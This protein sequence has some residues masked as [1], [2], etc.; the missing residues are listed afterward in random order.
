MRA[1]SCDVLLGQRRLLGLRGRQRE[2]ED[3]SAARA[4]PPARVAM[5]R[6]R[7]SGGRVGSERCRAA[8]RITTSS[9]SRERLEPDHR[10]AREERRVDLEVRVLGRR[11]DERDEPVLD[12]GQQRVLLRLVEAVDLVDEEDRPQAV[13]RRAGRALARSRRARR[14]HARR[15]PRAPRTRRPSARPRCGRASS[16]RCPAAPTGSSTAARSSSI[17][18]RSAEPGAEHVLLADEIVERRRPQPDRERRV[19]GLALARAS[20]KRSA[21]REVCSGHVRGRG[22]T[23]SGASDA[24]DG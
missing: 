21:T 5:Q 20:L 4:S 9:S 1:A 3:L 11:A 7:T 16:S 23:V 13:R 22:R 15:R 8:A 14:P 18:R 17:A 10:A 24:F 12:R 6:R 2:L 19:L